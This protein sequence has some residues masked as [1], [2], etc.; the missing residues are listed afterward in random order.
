MDNYDPDTCRKTAV[1]NLRVYP[2]DETEALDLPMSDQY[3]CAGDVSRF[4]NQLTVTAV[5]AG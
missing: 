3:G 1:A 4:G 2:P 5:N